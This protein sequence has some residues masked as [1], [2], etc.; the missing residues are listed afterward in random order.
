MELSFNKQNALNVL[1]VALFIGASA[2]LDFAI[3]Q[4][5]EMQFGTLTPFINLALVGL[6]ELLKKQEA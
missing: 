4:S 6:R 5:T 3:A 1:K 2:A